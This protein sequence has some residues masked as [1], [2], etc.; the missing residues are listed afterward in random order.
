M[1][2]AIMIASIFG[3]YLMI[4]G[5]W[6]LI[7]HKNHLKICES[8]RKTPAAIHV[9]GWTS[10]LIGLTLVYLFNMWQWNILFFVTLLGW[11]YI[12]RAFIVLFIPQLYL[13]AETHE[14]KFI[15][16]GGV[17]R[18]IWGV[19]LSWVSIYLG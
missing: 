7:Q 1:S 2:H 11:A 6:M 12:I 16:A 5:L 9:V 13:K 8:I 18:L 17:I 4:Q 10:L 15:K 3:P 14:A 19:V